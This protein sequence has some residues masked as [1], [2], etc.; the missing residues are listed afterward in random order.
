MSK[1]NSSIFLN[2]YIKSL[3]AYYNI[4]IDDVNKFGDTFQV[5]GKFNDNS[6]YGNLI[7]A[8]SNFLVP[9][10][11][12][13][14][15]AGLYFTFLASKGSFLSNDYLK[16][17]NELMK[18][19]GDPLR[20][21]IFDKDG[22]LKINKLVA[23]YLE[24]FPRKVFEFLGS[25]FVG[26]AA[27]VAK[28]EQLPEP[29]VM[30]NLFNKAKL[31]SAS[32]EEKIY[33]DNFTKKEL[34]SFLE[35]LKNSFSNFP[36]IKTLV[37]LFLKDINLSNDIEYWKKFLSSITSTL[38]TINEFIKPLNFNSEKEVN[39]ILNLMFLLNLSNKNPDQ[40]PLIMINLNSNNLPFK[41]DIKNLVDDLTISAYNLNMDKD[42]MVKNLSSSLYSTFTSILSTFIKRSIRNGN[43]DYGDCFYFLKLYSL[44]SILIE[45][46]NSNKKN[47]FEYNN[48]KTQLKSLLILK[49]FANNMVNL[50]D[51]PDDNVVI[52]FLEVLRRM[53]QKVAPWVIQKSPSMPKDKT[54]WLRLNL[55][56]KIYNSLDKQSP[57]YSK[58]RG[59]LITKLRN[60]ISSYSDTVEFSMFLNNLITND[61]LFDAFV[62]NLESLVGTIAGF[63][64]ANQ[65]DNP[66]YLFSQL[67]RLKFLKDNKQ[68]QIM[69]N[70][71]Q[72]E[73]A[74]KIMTKDNI[75]NR[76]LLD[77]NDYIMYLKDESKIRE[78]FVNVLENYY[79]ASVYYL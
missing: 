21:F 39:N 26:Q 73:L 55:W 35:D 2:F 30:I 49:K 25:N 29:L 15:T 18:L 12:Y 45:L 68:N 38:A 62:K 4:P 40:F 27:W 24:P 14:F 78:I 58:L 3:N 65:Y 47:S 50:L 9:D 48:I 75:V 76:A 6:I 23:N 1:V 53:G 5:A 44:S 66:D 60:I 43:L 64:I 67:L 63:P 10:F 54:F 59:S 16:K 79:N 77:Y 69:K 17:L 31:L 36:E 37:E 41:D 61:M 70:L 46:I 42:K 57:D 51:N 56:T 11:E 72:S 28:P 20:D 34:S 22:S 52:S 32:L 33:M 74:V 8:F 13:L 19:K 7:N 71:V